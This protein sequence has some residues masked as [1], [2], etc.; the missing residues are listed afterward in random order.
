MK[1]PTVIAA[2][3]ALVG[4]AGPA[5]AGVIYPG[6]SPEQP[7]DTSIAVTFDSAAATTTDLSFTIDGYLSLDGQNFYED[8][9][10]LSLNGSPL[11]AGTFNLGGGSNTTQAVVYLNP[12]GATLSNPTSNG[13]AIGFAGGKEIVTFGDVLPVVS[14]IN[15][16]I[17]NYTSLPPPGNAGFQGIGDEGWGIEGVT[18]SV[19]ET[20]T[21]AM[22]LVGF[23]G[24]GFAGYRKSRKAVSIVA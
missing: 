19:P 10:G 7:T 4:L 9:F 15:T 23:A 13:T 5:N 3:A 17:F 16:L 12:F 24:L 22:M 1:K 2:F 18:I 21:W 14:G 11:F 6:P 8:D 20:S